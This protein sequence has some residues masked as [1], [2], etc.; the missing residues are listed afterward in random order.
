MLRFSKPA[1]H[2]LKIPLN[3]VTLR[4]FSFLMPLLK[5][6]L[7]HLRRNAW[8]TFSSLEF[9]KLDVFHS[10]IVFGTVYAPQEDHLRER[11]I[12]HIAF[13]RRGLVGFDFDTG[14]LL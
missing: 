6:L 11:E 14:Q 3:S 1:S 12:L 8:S 10:F 2:S 7:S 4:A 9:L 13:A 5:Y